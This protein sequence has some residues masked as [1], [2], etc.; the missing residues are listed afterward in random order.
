[1]LG[2]KVKDERYIEFGSI[3]GVSI[4]RTFHIYMGEI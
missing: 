2:Q 1:M 4:G 3:V